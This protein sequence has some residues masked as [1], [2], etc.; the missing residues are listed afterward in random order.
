MQLLEAV[1]SRLGGF[2][3]EAFQS[4]FG[5]VPLAS[6]EELLCHARQLVKCIDESGIPPPLCLSALAREP[7]DA[8]SRRASG[9]YH[10][11]Y[12]LALRIA[13]MAED[14]LVPGIRMIDPACGSGMLLTAASMVAC[15]SDRSLAG[16]WLPQTVHAADLSPVALRGALIALSALTDDLDAL[17]S[18][19]SK[20]IVHDS[21]LADGAAWTSMAPD[22]FDV[23]VANPPWEKVK[24][25]RHEFVVARGYDRDYGS[26]Y[27]EG[28]LEG[29]ESARSGRA[30]LANAL[31]TRYPSLAT[32]EPDLYVAFADLLLTLTRPGGLGAL[33][34]PGGL[35]RCKHTETLRRSLIGS[36]KSI[37]FTVMH[38]K[39]RHF[40]IDTRFKFLL[41]NYVKA[42][43]GGRSGR[44]IAVEHAT[45][46]D[47]EVK[48]GRAASIPV[49]RLKRLRPDLT[50]P[51]VRSAAEWRLFDKMQ[52][53][54]LSLGDK[55]SPWHA[56]FCREVDMTRSRPHFVRAPAPDTLPLVEGRMVFQHRLGSKAYVSGEG[57]AAKWRPLPPGQSVALPQFWI[58][59]KKLSSVA[60]ERAGRTRAGFCD[61]TGQTN[62]RSMMAAL[63]PPGVVCGNKVPTIEFSND[64]SEDR[65][66]LWL[67]TVNSL[68]FDWLLRR[69]VTTTVNY[70]VLESVRLPAMDVGNLPAQRLIDIARQLAMLDG[71]GVVSVEQCWRVAALRAEADVIVA[72]AYRCEEEDLIL[73]LR[74]FPLLDGGQ[75]C[76]HREARS[77]ITADLLLSSW[78]NRKRKVLG[79]LIR[80]VD[81]A[82]ELGAVPYLHSEFSDCVRRSRKEVGYVR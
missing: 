37:R 78:R 62:E 20:W 40:D 22:G 59:Q 68:P 25:T 6:T 61:I 50:L 38:N 81:V 31:V 12:R 63:V 54:G 30:R 42:V 70:F 23:V 77:T 60:R 39:A 24:L 76:I 9:A 57:R 71:N 17:A 43:K 27:A 82:K 5:V 8:S 41:V 69:V 58:D 73:M 46:D 26:S 16:D 79:D 28:A 55:A 4:K 2:D 49:V 13:R 56:V 7:L 52:T 44:R 10:T 15:R 21:L 3:I 65:L 14:R 66:L 18:M 29:Y 32:G 53:G 75:P 11:D 51:E 36:S 47:I 45:A 72:N 19:R 34:V 80:R 74:D 1:A 35:I 67:A 64:P 33:I 48:A